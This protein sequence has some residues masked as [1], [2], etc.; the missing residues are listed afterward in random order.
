MKQEL[1]TKEDSLK[2]R[3]NSFP[4]RTETLK[5]HM[6]YPHSIL[7]IGTM[8]AEITS[9]TESNIMNDVL[10]AMSES[11]TINEDGEAIPILVANYMYIFTL[12]LQSMSIWNA[13]LKLTSIN[14]KY[15]AL[16]VI[17]D[18]KSWLSIQT[19]ILYQRLMNFKNNV[20]A[21]N[22]NNVTLFYENL[23]KS[24]KQINSFNE[25]YSQLNLK[26]NHN[27]ND[28]F[29]SYRLIPISK[30]YSNYLEY[31]ESK[32]ECFEYE[33]S[34]MLTVGAAE[35]FEKKRIEMNDSTTSDEQKTSTLDNEMKEKLKNLKDKFDSDLLL[36]YKELHRPGPK[37]MKKDDT[38][39]IREY[40]AEKIRLEDEW[41]KRAEALEKEQTEATWAKLE[42]LTEDYNLLDLIKEYAIY[43]MA[44]DGEIQYPN[45]PEERGL[46]LSSLNIQKAIPLFIKVN[47][48][49]SNEQINYLQSCIDQL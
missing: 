18:A 4:L 39:L 11:V 15:D 16:E 37:T 35:T 17:G 23:T 29:E 27:F 14:S 34:I 26:H 10:E 36:Y 21:L 8:M 1:L 22:I 45:T 3:F 7:H 38:T 49:L 28:A 44:I 20:L 5:Q 48:K 41:N 13:W 31:L 42:L 46:V 40:N 43:A 47:P 9:E 24:V 25:A 6:M 12:Y 32:I 30:K 33:V 2:E 19:S